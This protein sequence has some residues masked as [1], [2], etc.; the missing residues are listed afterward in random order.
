LIACRGNAGKL[1][2]IL[3]NILNEMQQFLLLYFSYYK[4]ERP[5]S[6]KVLTVAH[7]VC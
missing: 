3:E 1:Y 7:R 2:K 4:T 5:I 6:L